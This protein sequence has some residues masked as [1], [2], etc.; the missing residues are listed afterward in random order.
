MKITESTLSKQNSTL[1]LEGILTNKHERVIY[2]QDEATGLKAIV[3]IH[4]TTLGP[5]LGGAR[6]RD[7]AQEEDALI[8]VLRLSKG[9]TYKSALAGLDLGGG[10]AVLIGDISKLKNEAYLRK[11]GQ[12]IDSLQGLYVTAPDV[13][14]DMHDMVHIGKETKH[15]VGL[16]S[17]YKGSGDPS[18]LTAYGTYMGI[19][20]AAKTIYGQDSLAGKKVGIQGIGKVGASII[21]H[22]FKEGAHIY[23]TDIVSDRLTEIAKEYAVEVVQNPD[24]FYDLDMDIYVPCALGAVINDQTIHRLKCQAIAGAANNQLADEEKHGRMLMDKGIIYA[25][26]FLV[27][28]GGVINVHTEFHGNYNQQLAYQQVENIYTTCLEVLKE[29]VRSH[30]SSQEVAILLAERRIQAVR[31]A[32]LN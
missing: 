31:H 3:A 28:A 19:K 7:Y 1:P 27:N 16:P 10:K 5:A 13:N 18:I 9:M 17:L 21:S 4:N 8:D 24:T 15:V 30:T 32:R 6:M 23:I 11:Y 25:P 22:L 26:D 20:A 2:Y 29:S 12:F 14:T